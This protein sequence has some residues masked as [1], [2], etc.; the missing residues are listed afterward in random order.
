MINKSSSLVL[1]C[2]I[3]SCAKEDIHREYDFDSTVILISLDGFRWDYLSRADTPNL[4]LL[5]N[6]G[7]GI[8]PH[9]DYG[10][11]T[12]LTQDG[13]GGLQIKNHN[14]EWLNAPI[15]PGTFLINIGHMIQRWSNNYYKATV[16]RV[17]SPKNNR[18]SIPFFFEPNF[19]TIVSPLEKFCGKHNPSNY[20]PLHFGDYL[21]DTFKNSYSSIIDN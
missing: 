13:I 7:E 10:F 21:I 18:Y 6:I 2:F 19:D 5:K 1:L 16:H 11:L 14:D 12:I 20:K 8:G 4:D 15:I 9:I 17:V 3:V